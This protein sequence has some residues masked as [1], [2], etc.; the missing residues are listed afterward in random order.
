MYLGDPD[1]VRWGCESWEV[2]VVD[3]GSG[4]GTRAGRWWRGA[5][6]TAS[7]VRA[8]IAFAVVDMAIV[9]GAYTMA[10]GL[11]MLDTGISDPLTWWTGL[12]RMMPLLLLLHLATNVVFGA[13]GHVWEYASISE[14]KQVIV[15]NLAAGVVVTGYV[16]W[17]DVARDTLVP[18]PLSV[19]IVGPL[20]AL[21][22]MG[23]VRFRSR[24]FSFKRTAVGGRPSP[25][26]IVGTCKSA[27]DF[28]RDVMAGG[29]DLDVIGFVSTGTGDDVRRLA[30]LP[31]LGDL[32]ELHRVIERYG[33]EQVVV[34]ADDDYLIRRVVDL[35]TDVD[36][37]LR[38]LPVAHRVMEGEGGAVDVRDIE[39]T[40]LL[41]RATVSTD[42]AAVGTL[43]EGKRV[44]VTGAGG[45]IGSEIVRQV[46]GFSPEM[47]LAL[48][49]DE[50]H[51]HE[52]KLR[53]QA[54]DRFVSILAD[55]RDGA[56]LAKRVAP[57]RPHIIF[58]AAALK[59]VPILEGFPGEA[60]LTNVVG[61]RNLIDLASKIE[62]EQFVLI[63]TDK[64]VDP[65]SVMGATKRVAEMLVQAADLRQDG[66]TYTAVRFGNVLGSRGSVVPT[67]V[68]QIKNGG[69][70]TLTDP[71][72][73]RY[74]MTVD[75]AVQ[76]VLQAA[77]LAR[78]GEVFV[79]DMGEPIRIADLA[80]RLIRLA[81]LVP[82]RD[83]EVTVTG[84]R[85]GEKMVEILAEGAL[86]PSDHPKIS[87]ARPPQPGPVTLADGV[88]TLERAARDDEVD[89]VVGILRALA[90]HSGSSDEVV[91]LTVETEVSTV[92]T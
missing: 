39:L 44:L 74:F 42:L 34:A 10:L 33:A 29:G 63:S 4:M 57:Y 13:Y 27:A 48:D 77:T 41:P 23:L 47:V 2:L 92:W 60:V 72:M 50:T 76:L 90:R 51:L 59:H 5:A 49:N 75:E 78:G 80:R 15:S 89:D 46:L 7:R 14:A 67:F 25:T 31:I 83:I 16:L 30:G 58:H 1:G 61:T 82:G 12:T 18:I 17:V 38:I 21:A 36:V 20:L 88:A 87:V 73:T 35:C 43:I 3:T 32:N 19:A 91:D 64:A 85:P 22:G 69:P 68:E 6:L 86:E 26:L 56:A 55:V 62:A 81:G 8:D 54:G 45:S 66:C 84:A 79:L 71:N 65:A 37:R 24:L 53:C 52:T 9:V 28:A 11:R 70:V 40:D